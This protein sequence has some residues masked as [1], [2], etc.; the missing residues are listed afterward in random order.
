[1]PCS[2]ANPWL[3][4]PNAMTTSPMSDERRVLVGKGR[5]H[6]QVALHRRLGFVLRTVFRGVGIGRGIYCWAVFRRAV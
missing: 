5:L 1:M 3:L 2:V 4:L 6:R